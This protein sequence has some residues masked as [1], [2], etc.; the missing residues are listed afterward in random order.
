M[1]NWAVG[2]W[3]SIQNGLKSD[4]PMEVGKA[5]TKAFL[6]IVMGLAVLPQ[7]TVDGGWQLRVYALFTS[8]PNEIGDTFAGIA[9]V[10]AFLWIIITVWLQ[11]QELAAQRQELE[12]TRKE[13]KLARE[14]QQEQAE[15][16]RLEQTQRKEQRAKE[17]L[18]RRLERI[19]AILKKNGGLRLDFRFSLA[20]QSPV[21]DHLNLASDLTNVKDTD[22]FLCLAIER[23]VRSHS[24]WAEQ[25]AN[26][27]EFVH[28]E[29][30][31]ALV[32]E[33]SSLIDSVLNDANTLSDAEQVRLDTIQLA[34]FKI[35]FDWMFFGLEAAQ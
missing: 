29:F 23:L 11:S 5:F 28:R 9:G 31:H 4:R 27:F 24:H 13:L 34:E 10:L 21:R 30:D 3:R 15:V 2:H 1:I 16:F 8:P 33:L 32:S 12:A 17:L 20:G 6:A 26:G 19:S 14:A 22:L 35:A 7:Y 18:E 25:Q